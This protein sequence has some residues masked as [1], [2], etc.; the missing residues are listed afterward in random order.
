MLKA[1]KFEDFFGHGEDAIRNA[2]VLLVE[3]K[4]AFDSGDITKSEFDELA[5]DI[6]EIEEIDKLADNLDRRVAFK[7]ALDGLKSLAGILGKIV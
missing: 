2:A 6:L 5:E 4:S 3:A 1:E 7:E